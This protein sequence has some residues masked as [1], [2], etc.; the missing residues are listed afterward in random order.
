MYESILSIDDL[1]KKILNLFQNDP[2][3]SQLDISQKLN[4]NK[5]IIGSRI[6]KLER[7]NVLK[8]Q[9]GID[10]NKTEIKLASIDISTKNQVNFYDKVKN[11]PFIIQ[12]IKK[13]GSDNVNIMLAAPDVC[14]ADKIINTCFRNNEDIKSIEVN[15]VISSIK[16]MIIPLNFD[17]NEFNDYGCSSKNCQQKKKSLEKVKAYV[18]RDKKYE[19]VEIGEKSIDVIEPIRYST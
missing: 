17:I 12:A 1:D 18:K 6:L 8:T 14:L 10:F 9:I 2:H 11:C 13:T 16:D 19:T 7:N 5:S 4:V 3:I 15:Y